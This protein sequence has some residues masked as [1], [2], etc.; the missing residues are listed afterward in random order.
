MKILVL[1]PYSPALEEL[2]SLTLPN[3]RKYCERHG[4][5]FVAPPLEDAGINSVAMYGFRRLPMVIEKLKTG[6]YDWIWVAGC[7]V[8]VTNQ[9][10]KLESITDENYGMIVSAEALTVCMDS[11]LVSPRCILFLERVMSHREKPIGDF[12]EQSTIEELVKLDEFKG[13]RKVVPQRVMNSYRY[14]TMD[15]YGFLS[16]RFLT[17]TDSLGFSGEWQPGDFV[18]HCPGH[19]EIDFKVNIIKEILEKVQ[20]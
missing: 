12:H 6:D 20:V 15:M 17:G 10:I 1:S 4:Y 13:I 11:F 9:A 5:E 19:N 2:A 7:D 8:I 18:F 16:E 3:K 14:S